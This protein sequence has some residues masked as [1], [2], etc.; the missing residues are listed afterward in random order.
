MQA[1]KTEILEN[2]AVRLKAQMKRREL[3]LQDV[4]TRCGVGT[5]T[6]G[7]WTQAKNWPQV[8]T[9]PTLAEFLGVSISWLV[10]GVPEKMESATFYKV[11]DSSADTVVRPLAV[12]EQGGRVGS[13]LELNRQFAPAPAEPKPQQFVDHLLCYLDHAR[14]EEGGLW[15]AWIELKRH[16]PLPEKKEK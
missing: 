4:A 16:F 1:Q 2:F 10:T 5:S 11:G 6:V 3:I 14:H 9:L 12:E 7:A 13:P 8:E 15:H